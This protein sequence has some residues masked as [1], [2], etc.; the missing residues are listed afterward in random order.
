MRLGV[1]LASLALGLGLC[2]GAAAAP[3]GRLRALFVGIDHY[4]GSDAGVRSDLKGPV[5]DVVLIK[6]TL[7]DRGLLQPDAPDATG[8]DCPAT[9]SAGAAGSITLLDQCAARQAIIDAWKALIDGAQPG[10]T[11]L[12]YYSGHGSHSARAAVEEGGQAI[13]SLVP[14]DARGVNGKGDLSGLQVKMLIDAATVR[15]R[16]VVTIFDSCESGAA[17]RGLDAAAAGGAREIPPPPGGAAVPADP[18]LSDLT[19]AEASTE[20]Y[21]VHLAAARRGEI[22]RES[23]WRG[24]GD[25]A[26]LDL[27]PNASGDGAWHG[28]FTMA[29]VAAVRT[30]EAATFYDLADASDLWL[31]ARWT[32]AA[33]GAPL[34]QHPIAEGAGLLANF[35][36]TGAGASS[37]YRA[38]WRDGKL[39]AL[40][41]QGDDL[42]PTPPG[43]ASCDTE[44]G[45]L[46]G[47]T[48][49]STFGVFASASDALTNANPLGEAVVDPGA[50]GFRARLSARL[51]QPGVGT[52]PTLWLRERTH[53]YG[54]TQL[55][56]ALTGGDKV[57]RDRVTAELAA[58]QAMEFVDA[59]KAD[60][61][62]ELSA[63]DHAA[64][65][66][67]NGGKRAGRTVDIDRISAPTEASRV[68][69]AIRRLA[70]YRQLLSLPA[71]AKAP[72]G[73]VWLQSPC[74]IGAGSTDCADEPKVFGRS[75]ADVP[76][77]DPL[78]RDHVAARCATAGPEER[79]SVTCARL[80][81][82]N[83]PG[84]G[85][86]AIYGKNVSDRDLHPYLFFLGRDYSITLLYPP[87]FATD[88]V[89]QGKTQLVRSGRALRPVTPGEESGKLVL[90]MSD[91]PLPAEVLQQ[92]GLP[93]GIGCDGSALARVLCN[94]RSGA[95]D[96]A[97]PGVQI[98]L[99][100][101]SIINLFVQ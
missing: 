85:D 71:T 38:R 39:A 16:N 98:G 51:I 35:I 91:T 31:R 99:W 46:G 59:A 61:E 67:L 88:V 54:T 90:I 30:H 43:A 64:L 70:N 13:S 86:F 15:G 93:R 8:R 23:F 1:I 57:R 97:A 76:P 92:S 63:G 48:S 9:A 4:V 83:I 100:S 45:A 78:E 62:L 55:A 49:G 89:L 12:F 32:T 74:D 101:V 60:F 75:L 42:C 65:W 34:R 68:H 69:E 66:R 11:L 40:A 36:Q 25:D 47:L 87:A 24:A 20:G 56:V 21:R 29:L 33:S 3:S 84:N 41:S 94:A 80:G 17:T 6:A 77:A 2:G 73:A 7:R 14:T 5:N 52:Q 27:S 10:D 37:I 22:A 79:M 19:A 28:D 26:R 95:R 18:D 44:V 53:V 82:A 50:E 96:A 81:A 72:L 58:M